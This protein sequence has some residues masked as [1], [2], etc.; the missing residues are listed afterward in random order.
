MKQCWLEPN[1]RPSMYDV[2]TALQELAVSSPQTVSLNFDRSMTTEAQVTSAI[3]INPSVYDSLN[4]LDKKAAVLEDSYVQPIAVNEPLSNSSS[5]LDDAALS[6]WDENPNRSKSPSS[7][8]VAIVRPLQLEHGDNCNSHSIDSPFDICASPVS[9]STN[10]KFETEKCV[11][12][13]QKNLSESV[14]MHS[15]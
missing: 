11:D 2:T 14:I 4:S 12:T 6:K 9:T 8:P 5:S 10:T 13:T 15:V 1:T 7:P 3:N